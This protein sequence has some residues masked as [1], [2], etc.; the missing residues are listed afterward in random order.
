M[1]KKGRE[2][3]ARLRRPVNMGWKEKKLGNISLFFFNK[4]SSDDGRKK[5]DI[6]P[7]YNIPQKSKK[8]GGDC[9]NFGCHPK[10][11]CPSSF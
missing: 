9:P 10:T 1:L 7:T 6:P 3:I 5:K 8:K 11:V 4:S 2:A